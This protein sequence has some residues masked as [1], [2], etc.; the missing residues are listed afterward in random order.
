MNTK[1]QWDLYV[2][3]M[4]HEI[5][6]I[7]NKIKLALSNRQYTPRSPTTP[8]KSAPGRSFRATSTRT[9]RE[10]VAEMRMSSS[11]E[12]Y[13]NYTCLPAPKNSAAARIFKPKRL[14]IYPYY[15]S[16]NVTPIIRGELIGS[17]TSPRNK[18][19]VNQCQSCDHEG[20]CSEC[21][22]NQ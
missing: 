4:S 20:H 21:E 19:R 9:Q 1:R 22:D 18:P 3:N 13:T 2:T 16:R 6:E 17:P 11:D 15:Q 5:D 14:D 12:P 8:R 10:E 7:N